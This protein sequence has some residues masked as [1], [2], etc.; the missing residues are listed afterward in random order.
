MLEFFNSNWLVLDDLSV[1]AGALRDNFLPSPKIYSLKEHVPNLKAEGASRAWELFAILSKDPKVVSLI[2]SLEFDSVWYIFSTLQIYFSTFR[3]S[4]IF[5]FRMADINMAFVYDEEKRKKK[6]KKA[7]K[8]KICFEDP[9]EKK[10]KK[11]KKPK[12][13]A[14]AVEKTNDVCRFFLASETCRFGDKCRNR[15]VTGDQLSSGNCRNF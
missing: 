10:P 5:C 7:K 14:V 6:K 13:R 15:H 3:I 2:D 4:L 8:A 11:P 12:K 1:V 9:Q